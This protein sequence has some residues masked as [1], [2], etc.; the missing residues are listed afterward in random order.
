MQ[1]RILT[2][3]ALA[4]V[5]AG[6]L[7][8]QQ[9]P[10]RP[11]VGA[12]RIGPGQGP[13][14]LDG[15]LDEPVWREATVASG[16]R[17]REPAM[18]EPASEATEVR[19]VYD[20]TM[21]YIGVLAR[22][23]RPDRMIGRILQRDKLL[24]TPPLG[25]G[26]VFG[27]DD[28]IAI[29][30]DPF[31]DHRSGVVFATNPNGAELEA[32]LTDEGREL[33]IDWRGIWSV[34]SARGPHGGSAEFAIPF[35][36]LRYPRNGSGIWG[37]NVARMVRRKAE[38]TLWSG[39]SRDGGGFHRVSQ[40][41]HLTGLTALPAGGLDLDVKPYL[42][43]GHTRT[44]DDG[45]LTIKEKA[46]LEAGVDLKYPVTPGMLLDVSL[47]TDFAQVEA[48]DEQVNLTRFD[49]FFPKKREF[50]LENAGIFEYGWRSSFEA[51]PFLL[52]FSRRI[53]VADSGSVPLL[54]G[55]RLTGRA[56]RQT[57]GLLDGVI[58]D[59]FGEPRT[60][61]AVLRAKRD[62][63][64]S[65]FLGA[66]VVDRRSSAG[67]NT[68]GGVDWSLWPSRSL[69]LQGF[70]A[71]TTTRDGAGDGWAF[72]GAAVGDR[73]RI[74]FE[75]GHLAVSPNA[76]ADAGFITRTDIL[77]S[78]FTLRV[79]P[80]PP[81]AG[82][83]MV[84]LFLFG[85]HAMN[86]AGRL[87]DWSLGPDIGPKW[88][89]GESISLYGTWGSNRID[90][91]F[92]L[93]DRVDVPTGVY[94]FW[95]LGWFANSSTRRPVVL[96]STASLKGMFGGRVDSY[97]G[98]LAVAPNRNLSLTTRWTHNRVRLPGG[99]FD[100]DIG[101][102]RVTLATSPRF[103]ANA[104]VQYNSLDNTVAANLRLAYTLRPGSDLFFVLNE[105]RGNEERLWARG[106][107]AV[108]MKVTWLSRL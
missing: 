72:R 92:S 49:L 85:N 70:A 27:G 1:R 48:D 20:G 69:N 32:L 10:P 90:S 19:V 100:A 79:S 33:N 63:A 53:G 105:Q 97:T 75:V 30:L 84:D 54:G 47:N 64:G 66:M 55:A 22:D 91:T 96:R 25:S 73:D 9:G 40:A 29:L 67:S 86:T 82:I 21:L 38:E 50:F 42:L 102:L 59:K 6:L 106:D 8:V 68:A 43:T 26:V 81:A 56:G 35:R 31:D 87:Q 41:G 4:G 62:V 7:S 104:L 83:R 57:V 101:A 28:A 11:S 17:Q 65:G 5:T 14:H 2:A 3:V 44:V 94:D 45:G 16:F 52:F 23:S 12:Y 37:F 98:E 61:F 99:E 58:E 71:G 74:G 93:A 36:T 77:R 76:T 107:R 103:V 24:S 95:E 46:R 51:P 88:N 89:S 60:N 108:L 39:W 13:V 15:R 78:D 80:R 18:G 34:A